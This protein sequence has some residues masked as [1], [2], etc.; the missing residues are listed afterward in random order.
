[1]FEINNNSAFQRQRKTKEMEAIS[2]SN[3]AVCKG[4]HPSYVLFVCLIQNQSAIIQIQAQRA[5]LVQ[6]RA[7]STRNRC[8]QAASVAVRYSAHLTAPYSGLSQEKRLLPRLKRGSVEII[9]AYAKYPVHDADEAWTP[10]RKESQQHQQT[11][12]GETQKRRSRKPTNAPDA[13]PPAHNL[14]S[15]YRLGRVLHCV[16]AKMAN[17]KTGRSLASHQLRTKSFFG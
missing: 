14:C 8:A 9:S 2:I 13:F 15:T 11:T 7:L 16:V 17:M 3:Q 1:M 6:H 10:K 4:V 5:L 12:G